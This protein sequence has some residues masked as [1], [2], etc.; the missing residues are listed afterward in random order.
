MEKGS[1]NKLAKTAKKT[2]PT[3]SKLDSSSITTGR[4]SI[5]TNTIHPITTLTAAS[6]APCHLNCLLPV[7][8][9]LFI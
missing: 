2:M 5:N 7:E 8:I 3:I 1:E 4:T 6:R 9:T